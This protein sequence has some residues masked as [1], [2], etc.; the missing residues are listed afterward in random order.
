[1]QALKD[2]KLRY[3]RRFEASEAGVLILD[4]ETE[5]FKKNHFELYLP[6][7]QGIRR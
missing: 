1:V 4:A 6:L 7:A 5:K 2:F 3:H